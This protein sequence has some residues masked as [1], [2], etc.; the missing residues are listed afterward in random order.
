MVF[1]VLAFASLAPLREPREVKV[2]LELSS[3]SRSLLLTLN[4]LVQSSERRHRV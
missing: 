4:T 3:A 2:W 1:G